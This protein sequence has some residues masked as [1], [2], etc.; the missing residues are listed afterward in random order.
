[1]GS[2]KSAPAPTAAEWKRGTWK[3]GKYKNQSGTIF[4]GGSRSSSRAGNNM[5]TR[6]G[7]GLRKALNPNNTNSSQDTRIG[8]AFIATAGRKGKKKMYDDQGK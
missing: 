6:A 5:V 8:T 2:K 1:M 4:S 3:N 7:A